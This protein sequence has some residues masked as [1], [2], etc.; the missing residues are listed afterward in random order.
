[1]IHRSWPLL[2]ATE[3]GIGFAV[4]SLIGPFTKVFG[5]AF[6]GI[7]KKGFKTDDN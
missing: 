1:M 3:A 5:Y 6:N 2:Q 7:D 4:L